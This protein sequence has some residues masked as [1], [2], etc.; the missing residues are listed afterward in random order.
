MGKSAYAEDYFRV[1]SLPKLVKQG[2]VC[3][4]TISGPP[5]LK[6]IYVEFQGG[7]FPLAFDK[8]NGTYEGLIGID[9]EARPGTY[10]MNV[11]ATEGSGGIYLE[12]FSLRVEEV[13]FGVQKLTLPSAM[14]DLDKKTLERVN[15]EEKKLNSLFGIFRDEKLWRGAF[16]CPVEGEIITAFGLGRIINGRRRSPHTG[17]DLRADKGTPILA[18]NNGIVVLVEELFFAGKSVI[19]DHGLGFYSMYFHLS[20]SLVKEGNR[21]DKGAVLGKVGST[22]RSTGS[23]LH[24]G[25]RMNGARVDPLSLLNIRVI[26]RIKA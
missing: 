15:K 9:M 2:E 5:S 6:S 21:V 23:H 11:V 24:W 3:P 25:I 18:C 19:L 14:V 26:S 20:E 1:E 4:I 13:D 12:T 17:V 16:I 7:K 22:G 10:E 8:Q